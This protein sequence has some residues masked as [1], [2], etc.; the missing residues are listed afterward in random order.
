MS[1][2]FRTYHITGMDCADCART[3]EQ[4]VGRLQDVESSTVNFTT[5]ILQVTGG[6]A[7]AEIVARVRELGY[8]VKAP[9]SPGVQAE[10]EKNERFLAFMLGRSDT[11][12]ALFA[13]LLVLP[14]LVFHELLPSLRIHHPLIDLA[15]VTALII[16]GR[17]IA[18]NGWRAFRINRR[19]T[20]NALMSIAAIGAVIIGA[21]TEAAV[22]MVLFVIGEALEGFAAGRAR[23]SIRS[24]VAA[25]PN[26]AILMDGHD[27]HFHERLVDVNTLA[28]GD[29]ILVKPGQTI[30]MDGRIAAGRSA[31]NQSPVTGE[32]RFVDKTP[33]NDVFAS[34]I[35]GEGTLEIEVTRPAEDNTISRLIRMVEDAQEKRAPTQRFVDRFAAIYTPLVVVLAA[36]TAIIPPVFM[37]EPFWSTPD[38][39][40]WLY[41]GLALLV[42]AC[43]CALVISTPVS[44]VSAISNAARHGV[45]FKGGAFLESLSKISAIAFDKTGTL[46]LGK[47]VL[48]SFQSPDCENPSGD[49]T[50]CNEL[51]ALAG[52]LESRSEHPIAHAVTHEVRHRDL[53]DIYPPAENVTALTGRGVTGRVNGD[54]VTIGSHPYFDSNIPHAVHCAEVNAA[55]EA[56]HTTMLV[57]KGTN[58]MGYLT[59]SDGIRPEAGQVL[60]ALKK[61]GIDTLVMLTGDNETTAARVAEI[62]GVTNFEANCLPEDKVSAIRSLTEKHG[63]VAM[64]GDG[65]NDT[66]ALA[67]ATVGIAVGSSPQAM[68]TADITLMANSLEQ[69]PYAV[70][71][72]QA[73]MRTIRVNVA[74]SIGIKAVFFVLVLAGLGTMWMAVLADMGTSLLVTLNGVRLLERPAFK[75]VGEHA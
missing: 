43:P 68:E 30:P 42:V 75:P 55:D 19:I 29:R 34:S 41:R 63:S 5:E 62:V 69:L 25:A 14:G 35:N 60:A 71:L 36:A 70:R 40:G 39:Q 13:V 23:H 53:K 67:T 74:L 9:D 22:V 4:G 15:S 21:Y 24:L 33:G 7:E 8:D 46:T 28:V 27:D 61:S 59:V 73:A 66:P 52:A 48:L 12:A 49:C 57:S 18:R 20:I 32:S 54:Q 50:P 17:P 72:S 64:V 45:I 44:L 37:G 16:A 10:Q 58:Y 11:K 31:V 6:A 3:L 26:Q 1:T 56:G 38:S 65:I 2:Q 47:P 51:L